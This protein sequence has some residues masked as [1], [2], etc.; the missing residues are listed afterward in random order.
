MQLNGKWQVSNEGLKPLYSQ[1]KQLLGNFSSWKAG[2]VYRHAL[3]LHMC[4]ANFTFTSV[5]CALLV[6]GP[7]KLLHF[8]WT[9]TA[10]C[11]PV[12]FVC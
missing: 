7:V 3:I 11:L 2:H 9:S 1:A 5:A 4:G 10:T 12:F 8:L 6:Q